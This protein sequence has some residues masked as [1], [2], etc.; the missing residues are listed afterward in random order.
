[1]M[2]NLL[3]TAALLAVPTVAVAQMPTP[4][5]RQYIMKA[6]AGD[7]YEIQSSKL[8]LAT[9][10]NAKLRSFATMMVSD[11]QKSTADV[12][13]AAMTDKVMGPPPALDP[14]GT[15]DVAALRRARGTARDTLYVTQQKAAHDKALALH[16]D[17]AANGTA[18]A[19]KSTAGMIVPV[20]QHHIDELAAM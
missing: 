11:H 10:H 19:L 12:K 4:T 3:F 8:V 16:Q 20:V 6:G 5:P 14:Q 1:M 7:Q 17:Y 15:R 13:K 2:R 18:T 9:T